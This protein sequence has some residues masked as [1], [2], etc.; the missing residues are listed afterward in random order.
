MP[1]AVEEFLPVNFGM[2]QSDPDRIESLKTAAVSGMAAGLTAA[3]I[4]GI[5]RILALGIEEALQSI[6]SGLGGSSFGVGVAIAALSG[7]LFGI[8]Y[9]YAIRRDRNL[10]INL[11][12]ILAFALV[13]GL[14]L[15]NVAAALSL[16]GWPFLT[17]V[18][19][20][21]L[22]FAMAGTALEIAFQLKWIAKVKGQAS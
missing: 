13:R 9:R 6:L 20:S 1:F 3:G 19:E 5:R 14:A 4:L 17:G 12:V 11:G 21:L 7:S 10:Q 15:V 22:I 2:L 16:G 18:L 8:T